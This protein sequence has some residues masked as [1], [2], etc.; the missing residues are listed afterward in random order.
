MPRQ[1][2]VNRNRSSSETNLSDG[3]SRLILLNF[4]LSIRLNAIGK[5]A[6][7]ELSVNFQSILE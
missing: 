3:V 6:P 1:E 5:K 2:R 7:L 4:T